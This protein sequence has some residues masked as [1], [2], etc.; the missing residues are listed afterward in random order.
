MSIPGLKMLGSS[1]LVAIITMRSGAN[2]GKLNRREPQFGQNP[3]W[4]M[5]PLSAFDS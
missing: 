1:R 4:A 2:G 5:F 3:R